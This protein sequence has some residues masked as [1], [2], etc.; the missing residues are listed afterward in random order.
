MAKRSKTD[1]NPFQVVVIQRF[2][3][4]FAAAQSADLDFSVLRAYLVELNGRV[5]YDLIS[6][7]NAID[8]KSL[9]F[10]ADQFNSRVDAVAK[11]MAARGLLA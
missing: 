7:G 8:Q 9:S 3:A 10:T 2:C 4:Y 5:G 6:A 1:L 11:K